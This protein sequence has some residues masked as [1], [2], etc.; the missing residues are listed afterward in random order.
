V[1]WSHQA[2]VDFMELKRVI[3]EHEMIGRFF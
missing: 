1:V 2:E 3:V